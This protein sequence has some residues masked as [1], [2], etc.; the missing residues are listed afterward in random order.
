MLAPLRQP[1]RGDAVRRR[2][3]GDGDRPRADHQPAAAAAR[4]GLA[5][6]RAARRRRGL[7]VARALIAEGHDGPARRAGPD[8]GD[9]ASPT[10]S[11]ACSR[12]ASCSRA[13]ATSSTASRSPRPT[14]AS[15]RAEARGRSGRVTWVNDVVQGIMLGGFYGLLACGLALMFGLMRIINLAHGD[16]AVLGAYLVWSCSSTGHVS[17]F[18]ALLPVLPVMLLIGYLLQRTLLERSLRSGL[19]VPL[20]TRSALDRDPEP[21]SSR[22]LAR[23]PLAR[24]AG[25]RRSRRRAGR[26]PSQLSISAIG[27]LTLGVAIVIFGGLQLFLS[28]RRSGAR[29]ARPRR[30]PTPPSWSASTRA[31]STRGDGDRRRDRRDRRH[32]PCDPLDVLPLLRPDDLIFA[33]EAVVIGGLGVAVGGAAR[34]DR[35][36]RRPDDRRP[37]QPGV[38]APRRPPRL[39][40]RAR[41]AARRPA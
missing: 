26:S 41:L 28:R 17:P 16:L 9:S 20:L 24:R 23:R 6:P 30:T 29:C 38:L 8:A 7:R 10:A 11:S 21:L 15:R 27:A 37:D 19:L 4:R 35:A 3:A 13:A 14:S 34:R 33:F 32:V 1:A 22:V 5:R 18:V 31:R 25:R 39:P 12:G 40:A 2:A 36:R